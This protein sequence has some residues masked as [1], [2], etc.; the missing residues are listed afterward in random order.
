VT[1][2]DVASGLPIVWTI[3]DAKHNESTVI[4]ALLSK[5]HEL[6]PDIGAW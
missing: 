3:I 1:I 5:L 2:L 4:V 6:W